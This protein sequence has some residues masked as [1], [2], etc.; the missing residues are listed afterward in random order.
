MTF[1]DKLWLSIS[2][3]W[4]VLL[5]VCLIAITDAS[6]ETYQ[7]YFLTAFEDIQHEQKYKEITSFATVDV[8]ETLTD[9]QIEAEVEP[10]IIGTKEV[11]VYTE[12][13][14]K[15]TT[16]RPALGM[17]LRDY[18]VICEYGGEKLIYVIT[19]D[20]AK[21]KILHKRLEYLGPSIQVIVQKS[22]KDSTYLPI[23]Q[24]LL[25]SSWYT[26]AI[27]KDG[28]KITKRSHMAQWIADGKP[29]LLD[30]WWPKVQYAGVP[31]KMPISD[32]EVNEIEALIGAE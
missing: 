27:D 28:N 25:Y 4:G 10:K 18:Q 26:G 19:S 15:W 32:G 22:L 29:K 14:D 16:T 13:T 3:V 8:Y 11:P 23:A 17:G 9:E 1:K 7:G 31:C 12:R 30:T 20:T 24:R 2:I 21:W 6:A 5:G